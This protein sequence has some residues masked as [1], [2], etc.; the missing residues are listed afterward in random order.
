MS[1]EEDSGTK[2]SPLI[3]AAGSSDSSSDA[4]DGKILKDMEG[5]PKWRKR[6]M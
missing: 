4:Q 5:I 2:D 6:P 3:S 1:E